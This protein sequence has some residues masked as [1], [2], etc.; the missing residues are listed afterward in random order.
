MAAFSTS[1]QIAW[2][3]RAIKRIP[4][5]TKSLRSAEMDLEEAVGIDLLNRLQR[6]LEREE[7]RKQQER[8]RT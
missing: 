6:A 4:L 1:A 3:S 7:T 5:A 2:V 8:E